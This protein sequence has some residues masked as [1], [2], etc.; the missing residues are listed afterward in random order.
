M[1]A[2]KISANYPVLQQNAGRFEDLAQVVEQT[3]TDLE[4]QLAIL[5][6][7]KWE[8]EAA[9]RFYQELRCCLDAMTRLKEALT[10]T[11]EAV[12]NVGSTMQRGEQEAEACLGNASVLV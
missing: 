5:E 6:G 3:I 8:A 1:A 10:Y 11:T 2:P 12:S 7:G 4:D 9:Q